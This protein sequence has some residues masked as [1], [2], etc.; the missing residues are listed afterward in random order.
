MFAPRCHVLDG[1]DHFTVRLLAPDERRAG[2]S[3]KVAADPDKSGH[4]SESPA[5]IIAIRR[6]RSK[7]RPDGDRSS[8]LASVKDRSGA[9]L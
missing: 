3:Q 4:C 7:A 8:N 5:T 1:F 2:A 6:S 9:T